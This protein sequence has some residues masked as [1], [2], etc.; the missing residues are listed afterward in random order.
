MGKALINFV[1][2]NVDAV[3]VD[4]KT[5]FGVIIRDS[6]GF[7]LGGSAGYKGDQISDG[8]VIGAV[9]IK[10]TRSMIELFTKANVKWI[11][12]DSNKVTDKLCNF[13]LNN[14]CNVY[15]GMVYPSNIP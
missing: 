1:K 8:F 4:N 9:R 6:D 11:S 14:Y 15:F 5:S 7:V 3:V 10:E 13:A 2:V 12:H